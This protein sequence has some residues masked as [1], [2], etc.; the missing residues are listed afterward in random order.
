LTKLAC[1][2]PG[3]GSQAV[4]MGFDL[5]QNFIDAG[6]LFTQIDQIAGRSLSQLCFS[7][8]ADEL[9]RTINTQPAI[10]A[11]SIVA[12]ECYRK[13]GGPEPDFVAGHSL[14]EFSALYAARALSLESVI[15][16]VMERSK[17]MDAAKMGAM[18]AI[19][20]LS[21]IRLKQ[22]CEEV[23]L[24]LN[25]PGSANESGD[26]LAKNVKS[27]ASVPEN[28]AVVVANFNTQEQTVISGTPE[29][30]AQ[31]G[32][33]AKLEGA[34]VLPLPVGGAFHSPLMKEAADQFTHSIDQYLFAK[35][36]YPI[37]QN[38]SAQPTNEAGALRTNLKRQMNNSVR[39]AETIEYMLVQ[40]VT[41]FVEIGPG[42]VLSGMVK[43]FKKEANVFNV[44][45]AV[46]LKQTLEQLAYCPSP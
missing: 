32:A 42:K 31:A 7:A 43:R 38:Y 41:H 45:D 2:F 15:R 6:E 19:I 18:S 9:K 29:A 34:K 20:G 3:Q 4:G 8:S 33:K 39:W 22:L 16:L 11:A 37:V 27:T 40:G 1:L 36:R 25:E 12:W 17:L 26:G 35:A 14:G 21:G 28:S 23:S 5:S 46:S 24:A 13:A 10:L 30:V 44:E